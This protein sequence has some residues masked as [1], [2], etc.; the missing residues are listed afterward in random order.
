MEK[1]FCKEK[2]CQR[3]GWCCTSLGK[4]VNLSSE[5][6]ANLKKYIF[7]RCGV[8]YLRTLKKFYLSV[9]PEEARVLKNQAKKLRINIKILPNKIIYDRENS[10]VIIYDY[11]LEHDSC[12]FYN[13][14]SCLIY[15]KR[16]SSCRQFP[17]VNRSYLKEVEKFVKKR[18]INL[19]ETYY[20][21]AYDKCSD[22]F[23]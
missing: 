11:Y 12:P 20:H 22:Y 2:I 7:N 3:C 5:E 8:I 21:E 19:L 9:S 16:P 15:E 4:E 18:R 13:G 23:K 6:E 1:K 10:K 17:N 14:N